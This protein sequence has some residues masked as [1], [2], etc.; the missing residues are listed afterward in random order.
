MPKLWDSIVIHPS[1]KE[2]LLRFTV[3]ALRLRDELEFETTALH[4]IALLYGPP[5]TGKTTLGRGL[6]HQLTPYTRDKKVQFIEVNPHGLM[7]AET[8]P[9]P[10]KGYRVAD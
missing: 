7:S 8:W 9:Q 10:A 4:G 2:R 3:L 5:G 6:A 1:V